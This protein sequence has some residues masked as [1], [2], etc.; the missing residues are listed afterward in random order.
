ML[1]LSKHDAAS[2]HHLRRA[3]PALRGRLRTRGLRQAQA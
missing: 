1:S 3:E 2:L